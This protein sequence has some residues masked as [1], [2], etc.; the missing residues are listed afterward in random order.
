MVEYWEGL[1]V[2]DALIFE[3]RERFTN[4]PAALWLN[5]PGRGI[6]NLKTYAP[7]TEFYLLLLSHAVNLA[8]RWVRQKGQRGPMLIPK[9]QLTHGMESASLPTGFRG[10]IDDLI[11]FPIRYDG[12]LQGV[13]LLCCNGEGIDLTG[14]IQRFERLQEL[15]ASLLRRSSVAKVQDDSTAVLGDGLLGC[16]PVMRKLMADLRRV[17]AS[18]ISVLIVGESGSGKELIARN[19]HRL[20]QRSTEAFIP[21]DLV[22]LPTQL[23]ESE[24]FGY[25][26]G[27]FTG[28]TR[29]KAGLFEFAHQGTLFLDEI[30]ELHVDLQAKLLRVIQERTFRRIGGRDLI[31]VD[32]RIISATNRDPEKAVKEN[33][34]RE[35]LFYRLN[36]VP[37]YV[38]PLRD[39]REDIP[40][41]I[42]HFSTEFAK[43]RKLGTVEIADEAIECMCEYDWPGNVREL[44]HVIE[45]IITLSENDVVQITDLPKEILRGKPGLGKVVASKPFADLS[46]RQARQYSVATF[47]REYFCRLLDRYRGNISQV[48]RAAGTSRKTIYQILKRHNICPTEFKGK[49]NFVERGR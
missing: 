11:V 37:I 13:F 31:E 4:A 35:D 40:L 27:A 19:I 34:L 14:E 24:L 29:R 48:A 41:L 3:I 26:R 20:S 9:Q 6:S 25:E 23:L 32:V 47:E 33:R 15:I 38:P 45:R 30:S 7:Q 18:E 10:E 44:Q 1:A 43:R 49:A 46:F 17:A 36:G 39:R 16:S 21:V 22:A 2:A 8:L 5:D 42:K 12:K 28:A